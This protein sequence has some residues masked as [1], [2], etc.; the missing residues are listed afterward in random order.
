MD[1]EAHGSC[2]TGTC[3]K[4]IIIEVKYHLLKQE[5]AK[6]KITGD[7]SNVTNYSHVYKYC[8]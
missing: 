4:G 7:I 3:N 8:I 5:F 6:M 1:L 2:N